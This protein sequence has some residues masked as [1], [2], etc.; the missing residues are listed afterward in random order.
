MGKYREP[1]KYTCPDID[2]AKEW[3]E[4]AITVCNSKSD[5]ENYTHDER[6]EDI[7]HYLNGI[8]DMLEDL[9]TSNSTLR[10]WGNDIN[11]EL[12][13]VE[14]EK[15]NFENKISELEDEIENLKTQLENA[16]LEEQL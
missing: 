4:S 3:I 15:N 10:D 16:N 1:I 7:K 14:N 5:L 6:Y 11:D 13:I 2:S 9:R 12:E 8:P